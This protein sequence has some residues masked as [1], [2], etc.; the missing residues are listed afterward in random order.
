MV[1]M[2]NDPRLEEVATILV[3]DRYV[4]LSYGKAEISPS[5]V[6]IDYD[7]AKAET[8][9]YDE[10]NSRESLL[11][12]LD[13]AIETAKSACPNLTSLVIG[14]CVQLDM[15]ASF[16]RETYETSGHL[17]GTI[18]KSS[19][20][21]EWEGFSLFA[22][23]C[24]RLPDLKA[25]I[26]V[27]ADTSLAALGEYFYRL[28]L[29]RPRLAPDHHWNRPRLNK[30]YK[31]NRHVTMAYLKLSSEINGGFVYNGDLL[32]G[33][34]HPYLGSI[35]PQRYLAEGITDDFS[36]CPFHGG[37]YSGLMSSKALKKRLEDRGD[38]SE[39]IYLKPDH[40][41]WGVL[42]FY[43]AELCLTLMAVHVP[44][45]IVFGG[46]LVRDYKN[47]GWP[48]NNIVQSINDVVLEHVKSGNVRF[49]H[50]TNDFD[51]IQSSVCPTPVA[52][53]GLVLGAK[54]LHSAIMAN[55]DG[56]G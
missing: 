5:P 45:C 21:P 18:G 35:R 16:D 48:Q 49:P 23:A 17:Y 2:P 3:A 19:S 1:R 34:N 51:Y 13:K 32:G 50:V 30:K 47:P 28:S 10:T 37:C 54:K 46:H 40:P 39:L 56:D 52:Y 14:S 9:D 22:F 44:T 29:P 24:E 20:H 11:A 43:A 7:P 15:S 4:F 8:Y 27:R 38:F 36:S 26:F 31:H 6:I 53:G 33:M 42:S 25:N 41:I 55:F 12:N